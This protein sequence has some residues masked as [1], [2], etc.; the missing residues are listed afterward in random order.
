MQLEIVL[1]QE[2]RP[3]IEVYRDEIL[4]VC[5]FVLGHG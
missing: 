3:V 2:F 4:G 1:A 5:D